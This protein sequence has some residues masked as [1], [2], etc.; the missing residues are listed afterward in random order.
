MSYYL[1][2]N[3]PASRQFYP[4]RN[5]TPTYA[6]GVHTSEGAT[7]PG[8]ARLLAKFI[9]LRS[10]PGSYHVI[11]DSEETVYLLPPDYTSFSVAVS[12][13][14]SRTW[15]ICLAGRSAQLSPDDDNTRAMI[16]RAGEAIR[17]LWQSLGIDVNAAAQWIGTD[18]L[19]RVGLF[20]H[21]DVQS[22]DRSDAWSRHPDRPALDQL[23]INAI[24]TTPPTPAPISSKDIKM[25]HMV[26]TD[27]R[28]EFIALTEGGQVVSCWSLKPGGVIGPWQ[29]LKPGI[30]GSNLVAEY[31]ADGRLCVTLAAMG[32]LWGSWQAAPSA[33]PWCDWFRVNDLRKLLGA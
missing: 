24:R 30:A 10:D 16:T 15:H 18:A 29:E 23:L 20:C 33:G 9:S 13:Y 26:N 1:L 22:Y 25:F 11:V 12:G 4:N 17:N 19:N 14:N 6:V 3:P 5:A 2:D 28:D 31:A 27:G 21:G 8:S 32:E 7:G